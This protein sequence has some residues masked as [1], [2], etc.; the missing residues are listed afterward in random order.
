MKTKMIWAN[1][2]T[3]N[4]ERTQEFYLKLGFKLNGKPTSEISSFSFGENQFIINFFKK[5]KVS[6]EMNGEIGKWQTQSEIIFSLSAGNREEVDKWKE[7][8]RAAGG[9]IFSEPQNYEQGYTFCFS[10]PDGHKF[11]VL[12]WPGM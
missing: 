8:V 6:N 2:A 10:D 1:L 5:S 7:N 12:Y 9:E 11:N 4:I 3:N